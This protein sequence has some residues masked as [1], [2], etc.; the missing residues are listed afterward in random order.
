[1]QIPYQIPYQ[2]IKKQQLPAY[3]N[4]MLR[5]IEEKLFQIYQKIQKSDK[6]NNIENLNKLENYLKEFWYGKQGVEAEYR[7]YFDYHSYLDYIK[8]PDNT[9]GELIYFLREIQDSYINNIINDFL[10]DINFSNGEYISEPI[11]MEFIIKLI[12]IKNKFSN[13]VYHINMKDIDI[14]KDLLQQKNNVK[15]AIINVLNLTGLKT[16]SY[17]YLPDKSYKEE[18]IVSYNRMFLNLFSLFYKDK[19]LDERL[20]KYI[21]KKSIFEKILREKKI[22]S[23]YLFFNLKVWQIRRYWR[24]VR[25]FIFKY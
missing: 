4:N 25:F 9:Y 13:K 19:E 23:V 1:M 12:E 16:W 5:C 18:D 24:K 6:K 21:P 14:E 17:R 11:S 3:K 2:P 22:L 8:Y 7:F 20:K 15:E 10:F